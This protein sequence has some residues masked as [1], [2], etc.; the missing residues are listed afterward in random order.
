MMP[1]DVNTILDILSN[2]SRRDILRLLSISDRYAYE[3]AKIINITPRAIS[4]HLKN[5]KDYGLIQSEH[6]KSDIGPSREYF[7]LNKSIYFRISIAKNLFYAN[8]SNLQVDGDEMIDSAFQLG[9]SSKDYSLN[10]ILAEGLNNLPEV[11]DE[12]DFIELQQT[13]IFRKYQGM[14]LHIGDHLKQHGI[15]TEETELLLALMERNGRASQEE[16]QNA[17]SLDPIRLSPI[18][19]SLME[20]N[21]LKYNIVIEE[22][23]APVN[24]YEIVFQENE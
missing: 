7:S 1:V 3:L 4:N 15:Q 9:S 14:L 19:N 13:R 12:L 22:G 17:L 10:D 8:F 11:K 23:K 20:K 18:V 21:L 24:I 5:L 6:R 16:L 2:S